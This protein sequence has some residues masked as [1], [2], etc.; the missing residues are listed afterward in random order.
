[1]DQKTSNCPLNGQKIITYQLYTKK[2]KTREG[3]VRIMLNTPIQLCK[4]VRKRYMMPYA[5]LSQ[6]F[7]KN[8]KSK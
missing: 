7:T 6:G 2:R 4:G 1:M 5:V 3:E 8:T